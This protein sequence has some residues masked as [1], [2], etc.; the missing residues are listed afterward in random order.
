MK[1]LSLFILSFLLL[2]ACRSQETLPPS[3]YN[4]WMHVF[5]E[6]T[7]GYR[8]YRPASLGAQLPP[9]HGRQVYEILPDN[10]FT[11]HTYGPADRPV[12]YK[13]RWEKVGENRIRV[14]FGEAAVDD[15]VLR[16]IHLSTDRLL[17]K[18]E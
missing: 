7:A 2:Q 6:D 16:I 10:Q 8:M 14:Q 12:A 4:K 17:L 3:L 1:Y 9:A 11:L 18:V 5:E 13:G 15:F